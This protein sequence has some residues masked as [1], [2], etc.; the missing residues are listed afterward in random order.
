MDS[1]FESTIAIDAIVDGRPD[2]PILAVKRS[3]LSKPGF[4]LVSQFSQTPLDITQPLR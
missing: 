3:L 4:F 1:G 2:K